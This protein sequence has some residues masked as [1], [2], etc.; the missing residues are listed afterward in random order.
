MRSHFPLAKAMLR[1]GAPHFVQDVTGLGSFIRFDAAFYH[2]NRFDGCLILFDYTGHPG[3]AL[4][5][6][7]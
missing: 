6:S 5:A 3:N 4:Q 2:L 1:P 7:L